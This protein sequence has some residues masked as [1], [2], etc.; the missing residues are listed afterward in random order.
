[1]GTL[2]ETLKT[3]SSE[4]ML[5]VAT[6]R[7]DFIFILQEMLGAF[8]KAVGIDIKK[9]EAWNSEETQKKPV[10]FIEMDAAALKFEDSSFDLV[11]LSNSLH[12]LPERK[13]AL[14]EMMRVLK[15]GGIFILHEMY[16]DG[17][18]PAQQTHTLLHQ[19]WGKIDTLSGVFHDSPYKRDEL[20]QALQDMGITQWEYFDEAD[21]SGDPF[22]PNLV[23]ELDKIITAYQKKTT[24]QKLI[25]EGEEL[26]LRVK[27]IGFHSAT[28]MIA[29]GRK[30]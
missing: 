13:K 14:Q 2:E 26:R 10:E 4:K 7:G 29:I 19:W 16:T 23:E 18:T 17:Q 9:A 20:V 6:G 21:L 27:S 3:I 25:S 11:S 15:P 28:Q 1:M 30:G 5:D 24:D 8:G 12:H 22:D